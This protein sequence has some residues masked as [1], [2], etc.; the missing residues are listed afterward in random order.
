MQIGF[1]PWFYQ[2]H[3]KFGETGKYRW[4]YNCTPTQR[5]KNQCTAS[6]PQ[7][8]AQEFAGMLS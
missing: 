8:L 5:P 3:A 6:E 1:L 2:C 7:P 4:I